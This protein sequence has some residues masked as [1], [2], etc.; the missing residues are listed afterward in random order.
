MRPCFPRTKNGSSPV[1]I[2]RQT[3]SPRLAV[4][5]SGTML[6]FSR[7]AFAAGSAPL[8]MPESGSS[9]ATFHTTCTGR[10]KRDV[11]KLPLRLRAERDPGGPALRYARVREKRNT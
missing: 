6:P 2:T 4:N 9:S 11:A 10:A 1:T 5:G 7:N 3:V 8:S